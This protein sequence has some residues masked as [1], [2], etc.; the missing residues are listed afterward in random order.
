MSWER[1]EQDTIFVSSRSALTS[2]VGL[3]CKG[4]ILRAYHWL[5]RGLIGSNESTSQISLVN[6]RVILLLRT[7]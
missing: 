4:V 5:Y 6:S 1:D 2:P 7:P 3:F